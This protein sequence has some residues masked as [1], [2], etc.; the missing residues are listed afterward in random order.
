MSSYFQKEKEYP[1]EVNFSRVT[2]S[3]RNALSKR[4]FSTSTKGNPKDQ[5]VRIVKESTAE[6][7]FRMQI[8][9]K[10][11]RISL[12][13]SKF[14]NIESAEQTKFIQELWQIIDLAAP[15][16]VRAIA[17]SP[18]IDSL[19]REN[20]ARYGFVDTEKFAADTG[21]DLAQ[22]ARVA[23]VISDGR[24]FVLTED[25]KRILARGKVKEM[26]LGGIR[27]A[28]RK[29]EAALFSSTVFNVCPKCG[30]KARPNASFC[31]ACGTRL[32]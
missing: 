19:I 32:K 29:N 9:G 11:S 22:V 21:N 15:Q 17:K 26:M 1:F 20:L 28:V 6:I 10:N 18:S 4:G 25:R 2:D 14:T 30:T 12:A 16:D 8:S 31:T 5:Q 13:T 23:E 27:P 3:L 24:Q 7:V